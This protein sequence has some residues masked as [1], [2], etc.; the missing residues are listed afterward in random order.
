MELRYRYN[1][2]VLLEYVATLTRHLNSFASI[3][4]GIQ[5][6]GKANQA[7]YTISIDGTAETATPVDLSLA[8][9]SNL[10]D[11]LHTVVLTVHIPAGQTLPSFFFDKVLL[12]ASAPAA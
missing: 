10:T 6:F 8:N 1:G 7:T 4:T 2:K 12:T 11:A 3:G 5:I 9:F